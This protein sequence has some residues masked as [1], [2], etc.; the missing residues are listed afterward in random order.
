MI[1]KSQD[2]EIVEQDG[3][4]GGMMLV[5]GEHAQLVKFRMSKGAYAPMHQHDHFE[6][7]GYIISGRARYTIGD[8]VH[9]LGP[10][11]SW[12]VPAGVLHDGLALEDTEGVELTSPPRPEQIE[13]ARA[14]FA[15]KA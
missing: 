10:G 4:F 7:C 15:A 14:A 12:L 8:E 6:Q 5:W 11:D 3:G 9:E 13:M 1:R 2:V